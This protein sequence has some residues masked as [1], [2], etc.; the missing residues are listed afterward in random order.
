MRGA[1]QFKFVRGGTGEDLCPVR[2][3]VQQ[4]LQNQLKLEAGPLTEQTEFEIRSFPRLN[5]CANLDFPLKENVLAALE[6]CNRMKYWSGLEMNRCYAKKFGCLRDG[7]P[8]MP[9]REPER[10]ETTHQSTTFGV[11]GRRLE[12]EMIKTQI[13]DALS[14]TDAQLATG[15]SFRPCADT[16]EQLPSPLS[17]KA[18]SRPF[19]PL[20]RF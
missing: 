2:P 5:Y 18:R 6:P 3:V 16:L 8:A 19:I 12:K 13:K 11:K 1:V 4:L 10:K 9:L 14:V 17:G 15:E 20:Q 7:G